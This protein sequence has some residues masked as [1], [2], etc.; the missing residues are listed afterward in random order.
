MLL[1]NRCP[2]GLSP[3]MAELPKVWF[4]A[5]FVRNWQQ[6]LGQMMLITDT[7]L[8]SAKKWGSLGIMK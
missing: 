6:Q 2:S 7:A 5:S 1:N 3:E 8:V 4:T